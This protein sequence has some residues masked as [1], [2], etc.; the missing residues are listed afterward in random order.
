MKI[1]EI[2]NTYIYI[3]FGGKTSTLRLSNNDKIKTLSLFL[4]PEK[5]RLL[6]GSRVKG[7]GSK[8]DLSYFTIPG[9]LLVKNF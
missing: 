7:S 8:F 4:F 2:E 3:Y 1:A 5:I 6:L 9:Q